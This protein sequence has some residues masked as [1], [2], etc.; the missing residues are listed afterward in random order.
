[1]LEANSK[2]H[3]ND[4][5]VTTFTLISILATLL[6]IYWLDSIVGIGISI[7]IAVT[8]LQIFMESFNVLMDKSLDDDTKDL[9]LKIIDTHPEIRNIDVFY[10]TPVG[11]QYVVV[12]TIC[13]D[14]AMS[15]FASHALADT[16]EKEINSLEKIYNT[17]IHVN[18]V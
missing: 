17:T 14:G 10:T 4:C 9:I 18:P 16:L 7:W 1:M 6:N 3:K 13:V 15:T 8:G 11:Y 2:D 12:L 5:I